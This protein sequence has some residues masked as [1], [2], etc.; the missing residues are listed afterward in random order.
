M[1]EKAQELKKIKNLETGTKHKSSFAF[2]SSTSLL[3]KANIAN[4]SLG[5]NTCNQLEKIVIEAKKII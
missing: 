2:E 3:E 4:I 5:T 1:R